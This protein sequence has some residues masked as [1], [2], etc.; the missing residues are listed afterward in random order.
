MRS[1]EK[2]EGTAE[3][4]SGRGFT[5][6]ALG[7]HGGCGDEEAQTQGVEETE[8]EIGVKKEGDTDKK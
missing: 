5:L 2:V 3:P 8:R 1:R 6:R 4:S 7:S